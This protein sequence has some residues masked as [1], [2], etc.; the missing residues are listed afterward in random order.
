MLYAACDCVVFPTQYEACSYV[1]L[2]ALASGVPLV[3]TEVGWTS[4]LPRAASRVSRPCRE[5]GARRVRRVLG[6]LDDPAVSAA[7]DAAYDWVREHNSLEAFSASG[8]DC[9]ATVARGV[10]VSRAE[11]KIRSRPW[12]R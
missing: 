12:V 8:V 11:P 2:E 9:V 1:V 10:R 5:V 3:T 7:V 6:R 4:D